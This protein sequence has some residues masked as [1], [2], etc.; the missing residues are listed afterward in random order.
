MAVSETQ[1]DIIPNN[2]PVVIVGTST[3]NV[4]SNTGMSL[5][6]KNNNSRW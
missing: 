2:T 4:A 1:S 5:E 3:I 6:Y